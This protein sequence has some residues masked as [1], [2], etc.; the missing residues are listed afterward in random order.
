MAD[1]TSISG[2]IPRRVSFEFWKLA[3]KHQRAKEIKNSSKIIGVSKLWINPDKL[4]IMFLLWHSC[5]IFIEKKINFSLRKSIAIWL[6]YIFP[7]LYFARIRYLLIHAEWPTL[8]TCDFDRLLQVG[9]TRGCPL[10]WCFLKN[11][12]S[13]SEISSFVVYSKHEN[14]QYCSNSVFHIILLH[15]FV[16]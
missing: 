15:L 12:H 7:G 11:V 3:S 4:L 14:V 6:L 8:V 5:S 10:T 9:L 1:Y 2:Y 13:K 16:V